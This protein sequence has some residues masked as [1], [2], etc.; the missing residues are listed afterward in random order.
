MMYLEPLCAGRILQPGLTFTLVTTNNL[1]RPFMRSLDQNKTKTAVF[2][3]IQQK[4][5]LL[6]IRG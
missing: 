3:F 4:Y 2:I 5:S 1:P 6:N